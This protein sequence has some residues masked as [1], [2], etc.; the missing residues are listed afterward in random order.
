MAGGTKRKIEIAKRETKAQRSVA[1]SKRRRGLFQK[2]ADLC[3]ISGASVAVLTTPPSD[4]PGFYSFGHSSVDNVVE[5]FLSGHRPTSPAPETRDYFADTKLGLEFLSE[6]PDDPEE[7]QSLI[8]RAQE[9]R[10][11]VALLLETRGQQSASR[12]CKNYALPILK[13]D[14][15]CSGF[16]GSHYLGSGRGFCLDGAEF[17]FSGTD[18]GNTTSRIQETVND[19]NCGYGSIKI[20]H[21]DNGDQLQQGSTSPTTTR[22]SSSSIRP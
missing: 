15:N 9:L 16:V 7:L 17:P 3:R 1:F 20:G 22:L 6:T 12:E 4:K 18:Q 5:A 11:N 19:F 13:S 2:A 8:D 21:S 14:V 10:N